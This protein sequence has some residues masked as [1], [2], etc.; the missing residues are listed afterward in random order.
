[1][2]TYFKTTRNFPEYYQIDLMESGRFCVTSVSGH[3]E[4]FDSIEEFQEAC[5]RQFRPV[6]PCAQFEF[7]ERR[8]EYLTD[9]LRQ[10]SIN[11]LAEDRERG[12]EILCPV[13]MYKAP[14]LELAEA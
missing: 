5:Q 2:K 12:L 6:V 11:M 8:H 10:N 13:Q 3:M 9:E 1:M 7:L 4:F 14:A